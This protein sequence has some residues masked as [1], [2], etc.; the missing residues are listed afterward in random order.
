MHAG[1]HGIARSRSTPVVAAHDVSAETCTTG[2][3]PN[4]AVRCP[5]HRRSEAI[6]KRREL[7]HVIKTPSSAALPRQRFEAL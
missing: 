7:S 2:G 1:R 5:F 4:G 6:L 3:V